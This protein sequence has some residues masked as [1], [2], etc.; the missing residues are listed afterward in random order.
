MPVESH[1]ALNQ[2]FEPVGMCPRPRWIPFSRSFAWF[3]QSHIRRI[4]HATSDFDVP[5]SPSKAISP[6]S[7]SVATSTVN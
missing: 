5:C 2:G 6:M 4:E 3:S 7:R 1:S